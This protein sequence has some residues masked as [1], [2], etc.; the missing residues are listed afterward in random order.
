[1]ITNKNAIYSQILENINIAFVLLMNIEKLIV[2]LHLN[3][4]DKFLHLT[5]EIVS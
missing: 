3:S 2:I 1:M 4:Y 5:S